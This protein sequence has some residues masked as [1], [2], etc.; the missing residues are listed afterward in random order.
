LFDM[1]LDLA[2]FAAD[3][4]A[5]PVLVAIVAAAILRRREVGGAVRTTNRR[6][7]ELNEDLRRWVDDRDRQA[8]V[9][10]SE[11]G[12]QAAANGVARGGTIPAAAGK[13]YR[14][15]LHEYRDQAS[16]SQ[17]ELDALLDAE[18]RGHARHR[19]RKRMDPPQL[20]LPESCCALLAEWRRLAEDD[21]TRPELEPR[22]SELERPRLAA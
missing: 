8:K 6:V 13:V 3:K 10:M 7:A 2:V 17:R 11:I 18:G 22:L 5:A 1:L 15:A 21:P 19:R 9:R 16:R 14:H 20:L 4:L 12:Q